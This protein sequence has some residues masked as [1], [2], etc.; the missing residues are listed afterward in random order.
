MN[1]M[2]GTEEE[3]FQQFLAE[4]TEPEYT[5]KDLRQLDTDREEAARVLQHN[6][7]SDWERMVV[8]V[9]EWVW[10]GPCQHSSSVF[11]VKKVSCSCHGN[12]GCAHVRE[13]KPRSG[14]VGFSIF[15][16]KVPVF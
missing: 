2:S 7:R 13:P 12:L 16:A 14:Y 15:L 1:K 4:P 3:D 5:N 6:R 8:W 10:C 11:V 9:Q